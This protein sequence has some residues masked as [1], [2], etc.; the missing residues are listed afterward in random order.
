M[1]LYLCLGVRG[2]AKTWLSVVSQTDRLFEAGN[3]HF[4]KHIQLV[5]QFDI[6]M[7]QHTCCL[8]HTKWAYKPFI[9]CTLNAIVKIVKQAR[10][11]S[12]I[13]DCTPDLSHQKQLS[14]WQRVVNCE[15]SKGIS[16][17]EHFRFL[18]VGD[19]T[20]KGLFETILGCPLLDWPLGHSSGTCHG[21]YSEVT[22]NNLP[23]EVLGS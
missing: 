22:I 4:L 14:V 19:T 18:N 9:K 1:C 10:Y 21:P 15:T 11:C 17:N 20:G 12:L 13:I 7:S 16:I 6:V 5:A 2:L 3:G 23:R 8:L